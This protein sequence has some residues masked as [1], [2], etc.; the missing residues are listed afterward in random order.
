MKSGIY[1]IKNVLNNKIYVG[2]AKDFDKRWK[3]PFF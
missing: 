1:Q 3:P 2:S